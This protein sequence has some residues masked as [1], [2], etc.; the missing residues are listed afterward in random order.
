MSTGAYFTSAD[1]LASA[2]SDW[3]AGRRIQLDVVIDTSQTTA[4][5]SHLLPKGLSRLC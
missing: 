2:S 4:W 3:I 5:R 1:D